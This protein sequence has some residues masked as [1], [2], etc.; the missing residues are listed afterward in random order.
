MITRDD[1]DSARKLTEVDTFTDS[2]AFDI[3]ERFAPETW[4]GI[5]RLLQEKLKRQYI[6]WVV[7][8]K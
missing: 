4:D 2:T 8:R 6:E 7:E 1:I 3:S 5:V